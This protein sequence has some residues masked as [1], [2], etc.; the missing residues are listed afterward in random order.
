MKKIT[1]IKSLL[2]FH[3]NEILKTQTTK[4]QYILQNKE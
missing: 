3:F 2:K 1:E 4:A